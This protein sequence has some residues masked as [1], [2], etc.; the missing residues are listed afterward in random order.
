MSFSVAATVAVPRFPRSSLL[1]S[2][3]RQLSLACCTRRH[4]ISLLNTEPDAATRERRQED[5]LP[6]YKHLLPWIT[7]AIME[8]PL[9]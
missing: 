2:S 1:C 9:A 6:S 7:A 3:H 4:F 8:S 5:N